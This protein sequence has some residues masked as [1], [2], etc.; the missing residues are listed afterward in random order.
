MILIP[1][2][3]TEMV[4]RQKTYVNVDEPREIRVSPFEE[5]AAESLSRR[6]VLKGALGAGVVAFLGGPGRFVSQVLAASPLLGFTSIPVSKDDAVHLPPGYVYD[7]LL[8]WGDP[9]SDGP[10]FKEDGSNSTADQAVQAGMAHDG[11]HLF[12]LPKGSPLTD[13][14]LLAINFEYTDDGLLHA[15]GMKTWS[16]EKVQKSKNAH[17]IGVIEVR[18]KGGKWSV[19]RPSRYA[20]RITADTPMFLSGPAAG[21]PLG[22]AALHPTGRMAL[23]T[24]N[25]CAHGVT[26]WGP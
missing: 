11:M 15:D 19:V 18:R 3:R 24:W 22:R 23:G 12:P 16:A 14:G 17:G 21:H 6:Q 20:R 2:S 1:I 9:V 4:K 26:P 13:R 7:V 5:L 8:A 10:A 25:N